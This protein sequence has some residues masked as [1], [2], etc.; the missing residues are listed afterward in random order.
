MNN[1]SSFI[2][3]LQ[4]HG[5]IHDSK[6]CSTTQLLCL[7]PGCT[8]KTDMMKSYLAAVVLNDHH[9]TQHMHPVTALGTMLPGPTTTPTVLQPQA[10]VI[11]TA[12]TTRSTHDT[13][14]FAT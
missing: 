13:A 2:Q 9:Q 10:E 7:H 1:E 6:L 4:A 5:Q 8:F 12:Q 3:I 11:T 14:T